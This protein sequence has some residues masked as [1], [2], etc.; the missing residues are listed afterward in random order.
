MINKYELSSYFLI[1]F[2]KDRFICLLSK[3]DIV[4]VFT[5]FWTTLS[6]SK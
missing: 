5:G 4:R 2:P 1:R 3:V 6:K